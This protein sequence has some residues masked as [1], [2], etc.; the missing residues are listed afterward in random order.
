MDDDGKISE[1][2]FAVLVGKLIDDEDVR[3]QGEY[4]K[5][6]AYIGKAG[7]QTHLSC[8]PKCPPLPSVQDVGVAGATKPE[9]VFRI[10]KEGS[11]DLPL[12]GA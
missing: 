3:G 11:K 9:K 7:M 4:A 12:Q 1:A 10:F 2:E 5:W 6:A 8:A